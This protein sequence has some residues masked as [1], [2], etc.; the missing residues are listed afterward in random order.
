MRTIHDSE[1]RGLS[2]SGMIEY[3]ERRRLSETYFQEDSNGS[4]QITEAAWQVIL[5]QMRAHTQTICDIEVER[6]IKR[7]RQEAYDEGYA[8]GY[9]DGVDD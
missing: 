4:F 2:L 5:T 3:V 9:E 1:I 8:A 6:A 7:V